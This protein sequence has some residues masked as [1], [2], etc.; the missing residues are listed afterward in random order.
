MAAH[1]PARSDPTA[2]ALRDAILASFEVESA[3][4]ERDL[5]ELLDGL[6]RAG[7]IEVRDEAPR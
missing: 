5:L 1:Q 3:T 7:L 4:C 2:E 6:E